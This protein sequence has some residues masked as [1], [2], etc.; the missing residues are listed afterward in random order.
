M[1]DGILPDFSLTDNITLPILKNFGNSVGLLSRSRLNEL[2]EG[3]VKK[4]RVAA[5][6]AGVPIRTLSG[7]NQQ[8]VLIAKWL[9][10]KP[11]VFMLDDP[12]VGIDIGSKDEIRQVI[13]QI[14][15]E[16]VGIIIFTTEIQDIE[17]LCDRAFV[18]FRGSIVGEFEGENLDHNKI[19]QASVSGAMS[20]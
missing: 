15:S 3:Y 14:A 20:A 10:T 11:K 2:G 5:P 16:G 12:T 8:K 6:N 4:M 7:G 1:K 19:L 13:E 18:M 17:Q 9:A